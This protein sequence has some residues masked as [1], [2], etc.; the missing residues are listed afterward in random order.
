M[1]TAR[2]QA[3]FYALA[4]LAVAAAAPAQAADRRAAAFQDVL[5]CRTVTEAAARLSCYDA[6][7]GR[8]DEAESRGDI[9]VIDRA[10]AS[11][12]HRQAFGLQL[13]SLA[14]VTRALKPEEVDSIDGV[15][16]AAHQDV[17]GRWTMSLADGASWRQISGQVNRDPQRGS[18]VKIRKGTL[19]SFLMNI[20]GQPAIKVHRDQ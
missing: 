20:D 1:S 4:A 15:V 3:V 9:V 19:G 11:A 17:N 16:S 5:Q 6:A 12:A 7:A 10:Q 14:F 8:M 18:K 2:R 13:P